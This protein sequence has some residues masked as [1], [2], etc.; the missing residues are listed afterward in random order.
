MQHDRDTGIRRWFFTTVNYWP[1]LQIFSGTIWISE[2]NAAKLKFSWTICLNETLIVIAW[3]HIEDYV[4]LVA[5]SK[6]RQPICPLPHTWKDIS[7][8]A[9]HSTSGD[10]KRQAFWRPCT[11]CGWICSSQAYCLATSKERTASVISGSPAVS[12]CQFVSIS[13]VALGIYCGAGLG[14]MLCVDCW[15]RWRRGLLSYYKGPRF[16][17]ILNAQAPFE[18]THTLL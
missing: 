11:L 17:D 9:Q 10:C 12:L 3:V 6:N 13:A 7:H 1:S 14:A 4:V 16:Q 8:L 5:Q 18:H 15:K 2:K